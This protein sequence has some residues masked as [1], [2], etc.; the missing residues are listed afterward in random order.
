MLAWCKHLF[1]KSCLLASFAMGFRPSGAED[2]RKHIVSNLGTLQTNLT[3]Y[4]FGAKICPVTILSHAVTWPCVGARQTLPFRNGYSVG[5]P[6]S[7]SASHTPSVIPY[8]QRVCCHGFKTSRG[9]RS[10]QFSRPPPT[11]PFYER[12]NISALDG[13]GA[14]AH[15]Q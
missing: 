12:R 9:R 4:F 13:R 3:N 8:R 1:T 14:G 7:V 15:S 11:G 10:G 5:T 6:T 2:A